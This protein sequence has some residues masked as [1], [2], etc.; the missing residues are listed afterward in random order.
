MKVSRQFK[1][2]FTAIG[3]FLL[4]VFVLVVCLV[5]VLSASRLANT[6]LGILLAVVLGFLL[7]A[8]ILFGI[9]QIIVIVVR[10]RSE[11]EK[12]PPTSL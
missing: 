10:A 3:F 1:E 9:W 11:R 12:K 2:N 7:V 5:T 4:S 8:L 6:A